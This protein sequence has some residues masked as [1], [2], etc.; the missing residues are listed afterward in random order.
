M[1]IGRDR[2]RRTLT[3]SQ[4]RYIEDIL[5]HHGMSA[6]WPVTTPI[7]VHLKLNKLSEPTI[8]AKQYQSALGSLMYTMLGMRPDIAFAVGTVELLLFH[9]LYNQALLI[10][11][12]LMFCYATIHRLHSFSSYL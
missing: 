6:C 3:I 12:Y 11:T 4:G 2:A 1:E 10:R 9:M 8:D 7:E 5:E